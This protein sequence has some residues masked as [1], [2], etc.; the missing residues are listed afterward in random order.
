VEVC[1]ACYWDRCKIIG[2][3]LEMKMSVC[4]KCN[5]SDV[6][7]ASEVESNTY[8]GEEYFVSIEY[9]SC[10]SCHR[11][12]ISKP[13][14]IANEAKVREAKKKIGRLSDMLNEI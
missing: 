6:A 9:S 3:L 1:E 13:Q 5:S 14:I 12:F 11:E 4:H 10:N 8:K 7:H 2:S